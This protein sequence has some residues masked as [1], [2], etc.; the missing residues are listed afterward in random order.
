ML[1]DEICAEEIKAGKHAFCYTP[2]NYAA[3]SLVQRM[4]KETADL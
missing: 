3:P 1:I 2:N 4:S